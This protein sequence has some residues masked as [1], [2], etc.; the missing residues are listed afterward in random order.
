M[1]QRL[2]ITTVDGTLAYDDNVQSW[3]T[4]GYRIFDYEYQCTQVSVNVAGDTTFIDSLMF[5]GIT[6][7]KNDYGNFVGWGNFTLRHG[8]IYTLG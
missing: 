5:N 7:N 6:L 4:H 3:E 2:V 1:V 8:D